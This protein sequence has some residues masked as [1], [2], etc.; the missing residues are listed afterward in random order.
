MR[1]LVVAGGLNE[2]VGSVFLSGSV[3]V[4]STT[5]STYGLTDGGVYRTSVFHAERKKSGLSF[6]LALT[7]FYSAPSLCT[8]T[9]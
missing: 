4:S 7:G 9:P 3:T 5:A 8:R 1:L 2:K 6:R